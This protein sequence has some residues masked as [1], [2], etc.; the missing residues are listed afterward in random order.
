MFRARKVEICELWTGKLSRCSI[1]KKFFFFDLWSLFRRD[2]EVLMKKWK[3]MMK[4]DHAPFPDQDLHIIMI[5]FHMVM[6]VGLSNVP[7]LVYNDYNESM[8]LIRTD[9]F[10]MSWRVEGVRIRFSRKNVFWLFLMVDYLWSRKTVFIER[11]SL[12]KYVW[13][14]VWFAVTAIS[15]E[16]CSSIIMVL[17]MKT[18][19]YLIFHMKCN[20]THE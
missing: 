6:H 1:S 14:D 8:F 2:M 11:S 19:L 9:L 7:K 15:W 20:H 3:T 16:L 17:Q 18:H 4:S 10:Q 12:R 13:I 5:V